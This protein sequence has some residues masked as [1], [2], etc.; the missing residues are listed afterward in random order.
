[1]NHDPKHA[2]TEFPEV[3]TLREEP[4]MTEEAPLYAIAAAC[5]HLPQAC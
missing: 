1:V 3:S 2:V 5:Q 4:A